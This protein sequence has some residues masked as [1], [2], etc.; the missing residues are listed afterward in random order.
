MDI[1][2]SQCHEAWGW[3]HFTQTTNQTLWI[4]GKLSSHALATI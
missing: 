3:A 2:G 4:T 1:F